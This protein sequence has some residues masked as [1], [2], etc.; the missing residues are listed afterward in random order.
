MPQ[1][2]SI[3]LLGGFSL[4]W[5]DQPVAGVN[6]LRSQALLSYLLLQRH[7]PQPRQQLAFQLWS[8]SS[9]SQARTN[10]RKE[11]TYLRRDLPQA[12]QFLL[13]DAKTLQ[14]LP[15]DSYS[16]DVADFED[17]LKATESADLVAKQRLLKQAIALYKGDLLPSCEDEWIIPERQRLQQ[18]LLTALEQL[19]TSLQ[20]QQDYRSALNYAQQLLRLDS[21]NEATYRILMRLYHKSGDRA[22]AIQ[23][24][25]RCMTVLRE[26]L[27]VDPSIATR[28]LYEQLLLEIE[29]DKE[30]A[31]P[32]GTLPF[33]PPSPKVVSRP[34][35]FPLVGRQPEWHEIQ[36][37]AGSESPSPLLLLSG[38]PGVGKTRLLEE[39]RA[40]VPTSLWGRGFAAEMIR[41]YGIWTDALRS[42]SLPEN[43]PTTLG[44]LLPER[45]Q[46]NLAPPDRSH[47]FEAVVQLLATWSAQAPI[48]V[49]LDDIQ[50]ID[51]A[52]SALLH[53][54]SRLLHHLPVKFACTARSGELA[55]NVAIT[56]MIQGLRREQRLQT[57]TVPAFD[58]S[59]TAELMHTLKTHYP[60]DLSLEMVDQVFTDS[61]GNPLFVL[62]ITRALSSQSSPPNQWHSTSDHQSNLEALIGDRLQHLDPRT[63]ELLAWAAVL[64]HSF[65]PTLVAQVADCPLSQ[66]LTAIE[67][68]EQQH[69]IRPGAGVAQEQGYEFSHDIVRQVVYRQI[70]EPRRRLLH[71]HIAQQLE[72]QATAEP[73][74]AGDIAHHAALGG[75]PALAS[76]A[77]LIA[78]ERCLKL[79]AYAEALTLAERGVEQAEALDKP[80]RIGLQLRLLRVM[81][82]AGVMGERATQITAELERLMAE[83]NCLGLA[84]EQAIGLEALATLDLKQENLASFAQHTSQATQLSQATS[85]AAAARILAFGG[86]CL[87]ELGHDL[88][89][90]E[91][92][93]LEAQSLAAR[94]GLELCSVE[95]SLGSLYLLK[96]N[97][98]TA[99]P[100]LQRAWQ[101]L[102]VEPGDWYESFCLGY[103]VMLELEAGD[104]P[105]ALAYCQ[106]LAIIVA[107]IPGGSIETA[108]AAALTALVNY[109]LKD[110]VDEQHP[111]PEAEAA[112]ETAILRLQ[113]VD[114]K[115]MLAYVLIGAAES[116]L[117]CQRW[118][119]AATR[120]ASALE[121]AET[122]NH[123]SNIA[124]AAA[125]FIQ[126]QL[127]L[128]RFE[129]ANTLFQA[130]H[131]QMHN[132][133]LGRRAQAR[134]A[135]TIQQLQTRVCSP[136]Q[137][138][139]QS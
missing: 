16:L 104:L 62:E 52:S 127:G 51:E 131:Q 2:L 130:H 125:L 84:E 107:K 14:W 129:Q 112:L 54:A 135:S 56:Q 30:P 109:Q 44:F 58:R 121:L 89:R 75:D 46:P 53:Y 20:V 19:I 43:L 136:Q 126:S 82:Y 79:F 48:I 138:S 67:Q 117:K 80:S 93:L 37:W 105:A 22:N 65:N 133:D 59:K 120:A 17:A 27:G 70:S 86:S 69:I 128:A 21:L 61:G 31:P 83:A 55:E 113:Q 77:A 78:A 108:V 57:I 11:L 50:W 102:Q 87:V 12:E 114:A 63:R 68:L 64:G 8:D 29:A 18:M 118:D 81:V 96:G 88:A 90:A 111:S 40:T 38:E 45:G 100:L 15:T 47:L 115:R 74:L 41:P 137:A 103:L 42:V 60:F 73:T 6:K 91:A 95:L 134:V 99:R 23:I 28:K 9:D 116:D 36:A 7:T 25:H 124:M 122:I 132:H 13:I 39:L 32:L 71:L 33:S 34:S 123:P 24:Y 1:I 4:T 5:G 85:P 101:M 49:I 35:L 119:T 92:L 98:D 3:K 66:L 76:N 139:S 97:Y 94:V 110:H 72:Q 106:Q 26:E 10:L